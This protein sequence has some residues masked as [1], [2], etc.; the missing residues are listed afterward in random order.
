MQKGLLI[1]CPEHDDGTTYLTYF[2]KEIIAEAIKKSLKNKQINDKELN[3][4]DFSAILNKLQYKLVVLNGHG[5]SNAIFGY[6]AN[7]IIL[8]GKNDY[9]LKERLV[10]ARSC[11]A[12]L[13]LGPASMKNTKEGCFIGYALPFIFYMDAKWTTKPHNDQ[14]AGLFLEPSNL[15]PI[16]IIKGHSSSEAHHH[17]KKQMLRTM[18]K[19]MNGDQLRE[20]PLYLEAL[21]N[22]YSGQVIYGNKKA[23]L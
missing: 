20:T 13:K 17:S 3:E 1:T 10:Y 6:K 19:L 22:N 21:W 23:K 11:H 14:V 7:P 9:L 5:S 18:N 15:I 16:S 4:K 12:G 2:S 8:I